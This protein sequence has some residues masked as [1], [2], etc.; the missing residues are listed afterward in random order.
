[1]ASAMR[2]GCLG[3]QTT[4]TLTCRSM[5]PRNAVHRACAWLSYANKGDIRIEPAQAIVDLS[6]SG[7]RN[8]AQAQ[9]QG[10]IRANLEVI[11]NEE[12]RALQSCI[13]R[14]FGWWRSSFG[15]RPAG[16]QQGR[17]P[18]LQ[19]RHAILRSVVPG[20]VKLPAV[21]FPHGVV[22]PWP[23]STSTPKCRM[24]RPVG[25]AS[26]R[27]RDH[28]GA[29]CRWRS[30]QE[31]N[32]WQQKPAP[33]MFICGKTFAFAYCKPRVRCRV[34]PD[35]VRNKPVALLG[36][37]HAEFVY[38]GRADRPGI[39]KLHVVTVNV[40][41]KAVD[42]ARKRS[43]LIDSGIVLLADRENHTVLI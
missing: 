28:R 42:R 27:P 4:A 34:E 9:V 13:R 16:N 8:V 19:R 20:K 15:H 40:P 7:G 32:R 22:L 24:W 1:M 38:Q 35:G 30:C 12:L 21:M 3:E 2:F 26:T 11:L 36:V 25:R 37:G 29:Q 33:P 6:E 31:L 43:V 39:G 10:E 41:G 18:S 14:R 23:I 5:S 17:L